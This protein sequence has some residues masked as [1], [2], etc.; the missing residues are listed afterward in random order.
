MKITD[1]K[2]KVCAAIGVL[3]VSALGLWL[4]MMLIDMAVISPQP[5]VKAQSAFYIF[6]VDFIASL[7]IIT[8]FEWERCKIERLKITQETGEGNE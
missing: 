4:N 8:L 6:I 2:R 3:M 7:A 1:K 5:A